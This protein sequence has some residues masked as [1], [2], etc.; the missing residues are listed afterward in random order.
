MG[1]DALKSLEDDDNDQLIRNRGVLSLLVTRSASR[2]VAATDRVEVSAPQGG[3]AGLN[4]ND[5]NKRHTRQ[6]INK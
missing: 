3:P 5:M 1:R 4:L 6:K 2:A